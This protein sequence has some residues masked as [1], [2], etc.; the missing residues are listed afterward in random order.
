MGAAVRLPSELREFLQ[1]PGPQSLVI[2]GPPGSGKTTLCLAL[3]EAAAGERLFVSNR[4]SSEEVGREFPWLGNNGTSKIQV[5]DASDLRPSIQGIAHEASKLSMTLDADSAEKREL[6]E[7]LTLPS[8]IQEAWSRLPMEGPSTVVV[9]SWDALVEH[10]LGRHGRRPEFPVDRGE[11]ERMLLRWMG[12]AP[13]HLVLV[14]ETDQPSQLDYLVNGVV[15]TRRELV[16]DRLERWLLLPKLRGIRIANASY[17]YTVEGARFQ[18]IEPLRPYSEVRRGEPDPE[19]DRLPGF[20]WPG[21]R[22]FAEAFGRLGVGRLSLVE[23]GDEVPYYVVQQFVA[24]ATVHTVRSGG[25]ALV[26]PAPGLS[27]DEIWGPVEGS[28]P[29][30][31]L[32]EVYRVLDASGQLERAVKAQGKDRA[33]SLIPLSALPPPAPGRDPDDNELSRWLKGGVAG[34]HPALVTMYASGLE[35]LGAAL[36]TPITPEV[37][38]NLPA[39]IQNTLGGSSLHLIA[40]GRPE[41]PL[42]RPLKS[43]ASI[44][45]RL[46]NRQGRVLVYGLKPWTSGF[47]LTEPANG[48][49]FELLRIV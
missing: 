21:S 1:L 36:K 6:S 27:A 48:G 26:I 14:L 9:D 4:V 2:R 20:V 25:R 47:V 42:F 8:P 10:Y 37:T 33:A 5:V 16:T 24:P 41:S 44:H 15:V 38:A 12:R 32:A 34:G 28:R 46:L 13:S 31:H 45:I 39:S 29:A 11:L 3:L 7:F 23:I 18:C 49:P 35:S 30:G 19:P 17:P 22:G 40:V 43:L